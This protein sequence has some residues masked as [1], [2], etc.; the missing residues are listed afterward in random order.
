VSSIAQVQILLNA[1]STEDLVEVS[2]LVRQTSRRKQNVIAFSLASKFSIGQDVKF[3]TKRGQAVQG[4]VLRINTK[5][6]SVLAV[7]GVRWTVSPS[8]LSIV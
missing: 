6:V 2:A 3:R 8:Y 4:K 1:M 7:D 5:S